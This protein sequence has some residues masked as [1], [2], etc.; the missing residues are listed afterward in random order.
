MEV[1]LTFLSFLANLPLYICLC[2]PSWDVLT[3]FSVKLL[4]E[5]FWIYSVKGHAFAAFE[6]FLNPHK[7]NVLELKKNV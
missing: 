6:W 5:V 7:T 4:L 1:V 2:F 3:P